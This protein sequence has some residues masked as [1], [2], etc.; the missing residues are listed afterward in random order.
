MAETRTKL[1]A[2]LLKIPGKTTLIELFDA[3]QW[4]G[5]RPEPG[6][7]RLRVNG[8]WLAAGGEKYTFVTLEGLAVV[9]AGAGHDGAGLPRP[10]AGHG[11]AAGTRLSVPNGQC[12]EDGSAVFDR[13][14]AKTPAFLGIDGRWRVFVVGRREPV[15]LSDCERIEEEA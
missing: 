8:R 15:L 11:I 1:G 5:E 6:T 3:A 10:V 4:P 12:F 9:L 14:I 2:V 13:V 7:V